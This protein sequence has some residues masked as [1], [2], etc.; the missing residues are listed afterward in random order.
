MTTT[1]KIIQ[2]TQSTFDALSAAE[3]LMFQRQK[4][5]VVADPISDEEDE[6]IEQEFDGDDTE[7]PEIN[8]YDIEGPSVFAN[9]VTT[10]G[11]K[12]YRLKGIKLTQK[13][14]C[15]DMWD[16]ELGAWSTDHIDTMSIIGMIKAHGSE[17][18]N[19]FATSSVEYRLQGEKSKVVSNPL[20]DLIILRDVKAMTPTQ[21]QKRAMK[22]TTLITEEFLTGEASPDLV[23]YTADEVNKAIAE[24]KASVQADTV[25]DAWDA[26]QIAREDAAE[27]ESPFAETVA[28]Q[29][30]L[31]PE[32]IEMELFKKFK[33]NMEAETK[34]KLAALAIKQ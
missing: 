13:S 14:A 29:A 10:I 23:E 27:A 8:E 19:T 32:Q 9:I 28:V 1:T 6:G 30:E 20:I 33:A 11:D 7:E 22:L 4:G 21:L 12:T 16:R 17:D 18:L 34:A 3:K 5:E 24:V 2:L 31:T 25:E 15:M 26:N